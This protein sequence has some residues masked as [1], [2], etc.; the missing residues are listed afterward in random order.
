MSHSLTWR[1]LTYRTL[2]MICSH[3]TKQN[4]MKVT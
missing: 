2:T 4:L 3:N 1:D